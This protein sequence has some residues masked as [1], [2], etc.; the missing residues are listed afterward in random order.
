MAPTSPAASEVF[1]MINTPVATAIAVI[2]LVIGG[3]LSRELVAVPMTKDMSPS[4]CSG[5][6]VQQCSG[7]DCFMRVA[8]EIDKKF[9]SVTSEQGEI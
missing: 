1:G 3:L 8:P 2:S 5:F 7:F 9:N 6:S 4:C